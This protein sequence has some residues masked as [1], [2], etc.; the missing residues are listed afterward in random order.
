MKPDQLRKEIA[1]EPILFF[2]NSS[3]VHIC[4][5]CESDPCQ[6]VVDGKLKKIDVIGW[7]WPEMEKK[8]VCKEF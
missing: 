4:P 8:I 1:A 2:C 5:E 7:V 6:L 3:P